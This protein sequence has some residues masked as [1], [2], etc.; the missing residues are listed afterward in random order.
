ME[1]MVD[2]LLQ[3]ARL[4]HAAQ[5]PEW[6]RTPI[7][8]FLEN[9]ASENALIVKSSN[10]P[11]QLVIDPELGGRWMFSHPSIL[12]RMV[13]NLVLNAVDHS[14]EGTPVILG[15][16]RHQKNASCVEIFVSNDASKL[17]LEPEALLRGKYQNT[18]DNSHAGLGLAFCRL[19]AKS[20][21]SRL[22]SQLLENGQVVFSVTIPMGRDEIAPA[23]NIKEVPI[24]ETA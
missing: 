15:A 17:Q 4:E 24:H 13:G 10:R 21:S 16:R 5:T 12:R 9:C 3:A 8:G 23:P 19:A 2:G 7:V 1:A 11:W 22:D 14:P 20:H 6:A 18:G